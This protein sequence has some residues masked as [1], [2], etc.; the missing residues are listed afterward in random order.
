M[1]CMTGYSYINAGSN[2]RLLLGMCEWIHTGVALFP[3][4]GRAWEEG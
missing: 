4:H 3:G 1:G 2:R